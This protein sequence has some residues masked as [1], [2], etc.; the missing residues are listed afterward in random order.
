MAVS[1]AQLVEHLS[2]VQSVVV[3]FLSPIL[4]QRY[5]RYEQYPEPA[6]LSNHCTFIS[7]TH[8]VHMF[9]HS[10]A[11]EYSMYGGSVNIFRYSNIVN[12]LC[13]YV[14]VHVLSQKYGMH[15]ISRMT[16][17]LSNLLISPP[18]HTPIVNLLANSSLVSKYQQ[19]E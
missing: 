17:N 15:N 5:P 7:W 3:N 11:H 6:E 10:I 8:Y 16:C 9:S 14:H 19:R 12:S 4:S 13:V 18:L 1:V 2:S